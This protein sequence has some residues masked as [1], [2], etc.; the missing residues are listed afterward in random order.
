M[1]DS[2]S[3][4]LHFEVI[5]QSYISLTYKNADL[6]YAVQQNEIWTAIGD[7]KSSGA[8]FD[9]MQLFSIQAE[10]PS[11]HIYCFV[12]DLSGLSNLIYVLQDAIHK[13]TDRVTCMHYRKH[14]VQLQNCGEA[15]D[16]E[17]RSGTKLLSAWQTE[18]EFDLTIIVDLVFSC[19][20]HAHCFEWI[21]NLLTVKRI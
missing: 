1:F 10:N 9:W 13:L 18:S 8:G 17:R 12:F 3:Q 5:C 14:V 6:I 19:T 21:S 20:A 2:Y 16:M 4:F 11:K 15:I 7:R